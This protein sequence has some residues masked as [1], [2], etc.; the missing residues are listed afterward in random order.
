MISKLAFRNIKKSV[1]DYG[2]Y[3]FTV[4]LGIAIFYVFNA[5]E[6][7]SAMMILSSSQKETVK[8]LIQIISGVSLFVSFVLGALIIYANQLLIKR[9]KKEFGIYQ[10]LG[11]GKGYVSRLLFCETLLVG[12]VSL[13][14]GLLLGAGLSQ[15]LGIALANVFEM[16]LTKFTFVFSISAMWKS[17]FYFGVM[18][19]LVMIFNMIMISR[20]RIIEM[21]N[22]RENTTIPV[23]NPIIAVIIFILGVGILARAYYYVVDYGQLTKLLDKNMEM[24]LIPIGLGIVSTFMIFYSLTTIAV[25]IF[26]RTKSYYKKLNAFTFKQISSQIGTMVVSIS[27]ICIMLFLTICILSTA[28]TIRDSLNSNFVKRNPVDISY[29]ITPKTPTNDIDKTLSFIKGKNYDY[30]KEFSSYEVTKRYLLTKQD[31]NLKT[32]VGKHYPKFK[33]MIDTSAKYDAKWF[34]CTISEYNKLSKLYQDKQYQLK[35]DQYMIIHTSTMQNALFEAGLKEKSVLNINGHRLTPKYDKTKEGKF[36]GSINQIIYVIVPDKVLE[37]RKAFEINLSGNYKDD[38]KKRAEKLFI[39]AYSKRKD[40][41][42]YSDLT[43]KIQSKNDAVSTIVIVTFIGLYL[44]IIFLIA[45]AAIL[46]LKSLSHTLDSQER[47]QVLKKIGTDPKD[48]SHSLFIQNLFLFLT[49]LLL[50]IIHSVAGIKFTTL[51]FGG[52]IF[53]NE[54]L[55]HGTFIMVLIYTFFY[56][57]YFFITHMMNKNIIKTK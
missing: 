36:M 17:I 50:A 28:L 37:N 15:L 12:L 45:S 43:T 52:D 40:T 11:M 38:N 29:S 13:G 8:L 3:F 30:T 54:S 34:A 16:N 24:I 19:V 23:K 33:S 53:S 47:Y 42:S 32:F 14:A 48:I 35:D 25:I 21:L 2:I 41:T 5:I 6:S 46:A 55:I 57:G 51:I 26:S 56:G 44:G 10:I 27:T 31:F 39:A 18:Y 9:R 4:T 49:P 20:M 7:Q 1:K 22:K